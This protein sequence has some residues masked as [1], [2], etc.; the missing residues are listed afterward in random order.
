[1][2]VEVGNVVSG[3]KLL[4]GGLLALTLLWSGTTIVFAGAS[5]VEVGVQGGFFQP[6]DEVSGKAQTLEELEQELGIR[7]GFRINERLVEVCPAGSRVTGSA[8]GCR[9]RA[10][11]GTDCAARSCFR[12]GVEFAEVRACRL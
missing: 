11:S 10:C 12:P 9:R 1:M 6:Y 5:R 8:F 4:T 2:G 7:A 3:R